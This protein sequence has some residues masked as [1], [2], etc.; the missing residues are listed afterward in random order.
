MLDIGGNVV[1]LNEK[2]PKMGYWGV[3]VDTAMQNE[4]CDQR[5]GSQL[6][7]D[8]KSPLETKRSSDIFVVCSV[9]F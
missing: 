2:G 3:I 1:G 6:H 5:S 9:V 8:S 4:S 7:G